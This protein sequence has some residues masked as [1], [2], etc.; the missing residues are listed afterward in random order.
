[1]NTAT[2]FGASV[3]RQFRVLAYTLLA[4]CAMVSRTAFADTT[5]SPV[6]KVTASGVVSIADLDV[7]TP[8]GL[9]AAN[10]RIHEMALRLCT[11]L[12]TQLVVLDER[13][14]V[15]NTVTEAQYRL[16]AV[17]QAQLAE[18]AARQVASN[19]PK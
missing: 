15:R 17:I 12:G 13:S 6:A 1:M 5:A 11:Q 7:L 3:H 2:P 19:A 8:A 16:N 14:C 4:L 18:R 9:Q 10:M